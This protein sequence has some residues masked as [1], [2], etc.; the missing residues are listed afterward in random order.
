MCTGESWSL[1]WDPNTVFSW[2][3]TLAC[4][5]DKISHNKQKTQIDTSTHTISI[6]LQTPSISPVTS[7][8]SQATKFTEKTPTTNCSYIQQKLEQQINI[9]YYTAKLHI[10][11]IFIHFKVWRK[12]HFHHTPWRI[13]M[14]PSSVFHLVSDRMCVCKD[15]GPLINIFP[16]LFHDSRCV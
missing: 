15:H 7:L 16:S 6:N 1:W 10:T 14:P 8:K 2:T 3:C 11:S 12:R 4:I 5:G 9:H 13:V